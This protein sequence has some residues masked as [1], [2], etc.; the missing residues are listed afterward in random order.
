[1]WARRG[2]YLQAAYQI[3][4]YALATAIYV[5][6]MTAAS[7]A[8][9]RCVYDLRTPPPTHRISF[10]YLFLNPYPMLPC[11]S[12]DMLSGPEE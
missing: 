10:L 3:A 8:I 7:V 1:M 11:T 4:R 12:F 9:Y 5:T 2:D 6:M